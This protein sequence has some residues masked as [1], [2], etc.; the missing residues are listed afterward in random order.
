MQL[1][2]LQRQ[3]QRLDEK[4]E[5]TLKLDGEI[6]R[7]TVTKPA[8]RRMNRSAVWPALDIAFCLAVLLVT[9]PFLGKHWP[10]WS[11][12]GPTVV[13]IMAAVA[14]MIDSIH[15]LIRVSEIDW[16]S[17]VVDIQ[18]SLSRLHMAKIRQFKWVILLSPLVWFCGLIVGLQWLMDWAPEPHF[19]L[20]KLDPWYVGGNYA[21]GV[22][23]IVFGHAIVRF[24]AS[25]FGNR[26]WWQRAVADIS[27]SSM[28]KTREELE[29]WAS[30][31]DKVSDTAS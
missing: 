11:L 22:L 28:K 18:S 15:Q 5:R 1:E 20:D 19:I 30:M 31:N 7:L 4:L 27:G 10:D 23:I 6:L 17:A 3:W 2:E 29:R 8:R 12:V 13:V 14:L 25:R 16:G 24:L 9:G 26:G 21:V